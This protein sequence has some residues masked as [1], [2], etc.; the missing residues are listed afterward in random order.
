MTIN[1]YLLALQEELIKRDVEGRLLP[2]ET[3]K[4]M[5]ALVTLRGLLEKR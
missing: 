4:G 3:A 1:D 2:K 5:G